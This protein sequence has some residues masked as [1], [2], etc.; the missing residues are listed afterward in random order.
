MIERESFEYTF[1][2]GIL[3]A[4]YENTYNRSLFDFIGNFEEHLDAIYLAGFAGEAVEY[5]T[6]DYQGELMTTPPVLSLID[7]FA[8]DRLVTERLL[9]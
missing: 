1:E 4:V 8:G 5:D 6:L 9:S 3:D 7:F 2:L